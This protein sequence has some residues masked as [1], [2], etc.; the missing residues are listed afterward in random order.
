MKFV[1]FGV[2]IKLELDIRLIVEEIVR[3]LLLYNVGGINLL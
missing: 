3:E 2:V 1:V